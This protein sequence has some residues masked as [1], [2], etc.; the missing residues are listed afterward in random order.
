MPPTVILLKKLSLTALFVS[1]VLASGL[2]M[3]ACRVGAWNL[4]FPTSHHE[5]VPPEIPTVLKNPAVLVFSKT[6]AF[7][8]FDGIEGANKYFG[9]LAEEESM[10][11][12]FTENSAVFNPEDLDRFSVV[13]FNN[14]TGDVLSR[15]QE[16]AFQEW[17]ESGGGWLG[18]HG[19][20]DGSHA[21]WTW[22]VETLIGTQFTAHIMGP[23]FQVASLVVDDSSHV[24]TRGVSMTWEHNEEWYSWEESVRDKGFNVL[25]VVD[26]S[27]YVP[28]YKFLGSTRDLRM[29]DHPIVWNRCVDKGR[30]L[31]SAMG[32]RGEAYEVAEYQQLLKGAMQWL[33][34]E[35]ACSS[36]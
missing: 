16:L 13:V 28:V 23:Q 12:F 35:T 9:E 22:Y 33:A 4:I 11:V 10:G 6:N 8:H 34:E 32:H 19:A 15:E 2:L 21:E 30:A 24:V 36:E 25:V 27:T 29:G 14:V 17:L 3:A 1:I 18:L 7:R 31:Y 5:S 26:E 20:G